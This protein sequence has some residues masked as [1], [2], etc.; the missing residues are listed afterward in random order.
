MLYV[1]NEQPKSNTSNDE[2]RYLRMFQAVDLSTNFYFSYTYDLSRTLSSNIVSPE[3]GFEEKYL[4]NNYLSESLFAADVS[5]LWILPIIHGYL[6]SCS[7]NVK[8]TS[9]SII[10]ISRRSC[11]FAGTRFLKRGANFR[12][13]VA[14][15][16]EIEQ[17]VCDPTTSSLDIGRFTSFVQLRGSVPLFWSQ[18]LTKVV[19]KPPIQMDLVDPFAVVPALHFRELRSTYGSPIIAISLVKRREKRMHE[20]VLHDQF[21]ASIS[22]L[23]QFLDP[24]EAILYLS[25]DMARC[26]KA[27]N[28]L[29]KLEEIGYN[30]VKLTGWFQ[31][32]QPLYCHEIRSSPY[33]HGL[34]LKLDGNRVLQ[35]G[36]PRTNCVDCLDRTNVAQFVIGKVALAYQ[37]H[38]LAAF[39]EPVLN[40]DTDVR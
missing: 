11:K 14:N 23:N 28:A 18:D 33:L 12:G 22:Y 19:G 10:L 4:W 5:R 13:Q 6:G 2:Q 8:N 40:W 24:Q 7:L 15:E 16:V 35:C 27:E 26:H 32:F 9:I 21:R 31:T 29:P 38:S 37:L 3:K 36:I 1:P 30:V 20:S 39:D 17:I 25:F 34:K